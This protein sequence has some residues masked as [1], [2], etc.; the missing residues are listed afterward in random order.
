MATV[1]NLSRLRYTIRQIT[2]KLDQTQI[3]DASNSA[4][5]ISATNPPGIDDYINDFYLNDFDEHLRTLQL[6]DFYYYDTVPNVGTYDLPQTFFTAQGPL[7]VDG[8]Q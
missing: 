8:Y 5:P 4:F 7:Y 2:G 1:W 6:E 3:P